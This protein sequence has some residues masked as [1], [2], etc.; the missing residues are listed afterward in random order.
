MDDS[1]C[2]HVHPE[3]HNMDLYILL[4]PRHR[5]RPEIPQVPQKQTRLRNLPP[6][7]PDI[8]PHKKKYKDIR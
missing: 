6:S 4:C 5:Y 3:L 1:E 7:V 2:I 8:Q